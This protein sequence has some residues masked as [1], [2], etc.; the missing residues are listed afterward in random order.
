M[1]EASNATLSRDLVRLLIEREVAGGKD[2]GRR[3][4]EAMFAA[5]LGYLADVD[6]PRVIC[7]TLDKLANKYAEDVVR[8]AGGVVL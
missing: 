4:A 7:E 1:A 5:G 8:G 3:M 2:A 6:G